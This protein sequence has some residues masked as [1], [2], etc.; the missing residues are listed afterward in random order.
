MV[1]IK[2]GKEQQRLMRA[3]IDLNKSIKDK[4]KCILLR[5]FVA[6]WLDEW[7]IEEKNGEYKLIDNLEL[8]IDWVAKKY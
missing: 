8:V 5:D 3:Y 7:F 4:S 1:K 6:Y 2:I